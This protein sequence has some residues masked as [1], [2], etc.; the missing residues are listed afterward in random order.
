MDSKFLSLLVFFFGVCQ[1]VS[2]CQ[3]LLYSAAES[4]AMHD[5]IA[6]SRWDWGGKISDYSFRHMSEFFPV[7]NIEKAKEEYFLYSEPGKYITS[8]AV[9]QEDSS[10]TTFERYLQ[11]KHVSSII[12][13]HNNKIL[14]EKYYGMLPGEL[15]TLQSVTKVVTATLIAR[16]ENEKK[17]N[18]TN[19]VEIYLPELK[20]TAWQGI[21]VKD[22]LYMQSGI[23]GAETAKP[24][25][26][27]DTN[28]LHYQFEAALDVVPRT[29][30]TFPSVYKYIANLKR[31][32][33]PGK[34]T[35]Y[36]S[37]NTFVLEWIAEKITGKT[38]A[39]LVTDM[40]W[41]PMGASSNAYVCLSSNG[42]AVGSSGMSTTLR[43]LAR[44]GILYTKKNI[45]SRQGK[46]INND[47]VRKIQMAGELGYQWEWAEIVGGIQKTGFGGQGLY[48]NPERNIVIAYFNFV[49]DDWK[50]PSLLSV[51]QQVE[52]VIRAKEKF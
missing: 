34:K 14:F 51:L 17:I 5:S 30:A 35:E 41:K 12:I 24:R 38:Y 27:T 37:I 20:G 26:F 6:K 4:H 39:D 47:Q 16:L 25:P 13:L 1:P 19:P 31:S 9:K 3:Q 50:D 23:E 11:G 15:H 42:I 45:A 18:I 28:N 2:I 36:N 7:A 22:I 48:V 33:I 29:S 49:N 43:D 40:I 46:I 21:S 8:I 44:F 10:V 32:W 52:K